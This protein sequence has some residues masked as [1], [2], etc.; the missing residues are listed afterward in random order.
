MPV[1]SVGRWLG[2]CEH[3][4]LTAP[5]AGHGATDHMEAYSDFLNSRP[6]HTSFKMVQIRFKPKVAEPEPVTMP[7]ED[8][9]DICEERCMSTFGARKDLLQKPCLEAVDAQFSSFGGGS[10][11]P[12]AA[13]V[14]ERRRGTMR[15]ADV[16]VGDELAVSSD[17]FSRVVALLHDNADITDVY[18]QIRYD[19]PGGDGGS[20]LVSPQHLVR[21]RCHGRLADDSAEPGAVDTIIRSA[22]PLVTLPCLP[23]WDL[24]KPGSKR[25]WMWIA[26]EDIRPDDELYDESGMTGVVRSTSRCC[27]LGAFAPLTASGE[28]LVNGVLCSCYAPPSAWMVPHDACHA[29]MWPVRLLD[30]ARVAVESLT[31]VKDVHKESLFTV[32]AV[33]LL[34]RLPDSSLHPWASGMLRAA[35]ATQSFVLQCKAAL[36]GGDSDVAAGN[37]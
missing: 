22:S 34:P 4:L 29:S 13:T 8:D 15:V 23:S 30:N 37:A 28:L 26:A 20:L 12:G 11:F 24:K 7:C 9:R 1:V 5:P 10:C 25:K 31:R 6:V 33:W 35:M 17:S 18:L 19:V 2:S 14:L 36:P 27:N 32:D 16:E 3:D 21:A